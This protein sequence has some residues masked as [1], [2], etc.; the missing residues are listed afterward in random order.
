MSTL[1]S[2]SIRLAA[3]FPAL[4]AVQM[5]SLLCSNQKAL[6]ADSAGLRVIDPCCELAVDPKGVDVKNPRLFWKVASDERGQLQKAYEILVATSPEVLGKDQGDLWDSGKVNSDQTDYIRYA[7]TALKSSQ[8]VFWKVRAWDKDGKPTEWSEPAKWTMGLMEP[9]DWKGVW[10]NSP[11]PAESILIRHSFN[12][13]PGLKR[14]IVNVSGL[15]QYE[16]T[17]ERCSCGKRSAHAGLVGLQKDDSLQH[18]RCHAV[19]SRRSKRDRHLSR[20]RHLQ[21]R[22]HARPIYQIQRLARRAAGHPA[23]STRIRQRH[24]TIRRNRR[25]LAN[26][27]RAGDVWQYL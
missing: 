22:T 10:I 4:C 2:R 12:V 25:H 24:D 18:A 23:S 7:G 11:T 14:A 21:R 8:D 15:G 6:A 9:G 5:V 16:L 1:R 19:A 13:G 27:A 20:Q 3:L 17:F 26:A